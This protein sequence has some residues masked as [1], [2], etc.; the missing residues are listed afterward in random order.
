MD[1]DPQ[2]LEDISSRR[3]GQDIGE[4]P[5]PCPATRRSVNKEGKGPGCY[6][7]PAPIA[8]AVSLN[9]TDPRCINACPGALLCEDGAAPMGVGQY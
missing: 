1:P 5:W 7:A 3:R 4:G 8:V 9:H 2:R 6:C